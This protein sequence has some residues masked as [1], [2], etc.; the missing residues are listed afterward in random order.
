MAELPHTLKLATVWLL[1]GVALFLGVSWWQAQQRRSQ[2]TVDGAAIEIR[3]SADGHYHW[4]GRIEGRDVDFLVDTGATSTAIPQRLAEQ[5]RLQPEAQVRSSTAGGVARGYVARADIELEGGVRAR[6][7][8]VTVLPELALPLLG[9][10]IL[11][12]M[13]FTQQA[14]VLRLETAGGAR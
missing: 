2:V 10:D 13:R 5:L 7:L 11:S 8:P 14:G 6:A 4:R 1:I 12:K 9:M 3:R